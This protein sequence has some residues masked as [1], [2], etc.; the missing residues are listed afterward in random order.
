[1]DLS[2]TVVTWLVTFAAIGIIAA[3]VMHAVVAAFEQL[4][5]ARERE[6][7]AAT[8]PDGKPKAAARL[9]SATHYT[10]NAASVIYATAEPLAVVCWTILAFGIGEMLEW[11]GWVTAVVAVLVAGFI[12]VMLIRALPR[13]LARTYPEAT[14]RV[15][16]PLAWTLVRVTAPLRYIVPALQMPALAEAEDLVERARDALEVEDAQLLRSVVTLGDTL[17]KEVMVPRTDM[18][19]LQAGTT[20]RKAMLLFMRSGFSRVPVIG[21]GTDDIRGVLYLKDAVRATWDRPGALDEPVDELLREPVFIPESVPADDLLR[22]MQD[23]VFHMA[24]VV[25]EYG[26]VAGLVTIEDAMEEIVG[27]VQDEHDRSAPE[28]EDLGDGSFRVPARLPL[29]ELGALFGMDIED[30]DVETAAG[31]LTKALGKV[32]IPGSTAQAYGLVLT[33]ERASGRRRRL[34][35]ILVERAEVDDE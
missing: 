9:A 14:V 34:M 2:A 16:A 27:E 20:V 29:D 25:D 3:A 5:H 4:P 1:M 11:E 13:Q 19:T 8:R 31:L 35:W 17:T 10:S 30:D 33:A 21:E 12:S 6:L 22:R 28:P 24:I 18:V 15:V 32:P 26:G 7:A 23:E